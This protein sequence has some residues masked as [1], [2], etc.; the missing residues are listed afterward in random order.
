MTAVH[1]A[2][3]T[4]LGLGVGAEV[5]CVVG[6]VWMTDGFDALHFTAAATTIGPL[7]VA[8]AAVLTGFSSLS[9]TIECVTACVVL[10]LLSPVLVGA[11]G[12]AGRRL[13]YDDVAPTAQEMTRE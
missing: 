10:F 5:I 12:R 6:V 13:D 11:T 4:L 8:T 2:A 7:L 3:T 1:V 9:G